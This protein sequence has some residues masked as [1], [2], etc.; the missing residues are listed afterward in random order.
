VTVTEDGQ[1][2]TRI[3]AATGGE[4]FGPSARLRSVT[5]M[6]AT[7]AALAALALVGRLVVAA[8]T[9]TLY[10]DDNSTC[11]T[12]CGTPAAPFRTITDA[13][14]DADARIVAGSAS[15]ATIQVAAGTYAAHIYILPNIHVICESPATTTIDA[16]GDVRSAVILAAGLTGRVRTDFSIRNCRITGGIGEV[17]AASSRIAGGG[18]FVLGDAVVSNNVITGNIMSGAEPNWVGA[19]VYVGYGDPIIIGNLITGNVANPPPLGGGSNDSL[20]IGG[21]IHVE[22]SGAG[23]VVTHARIEANTVADNVAQGEVGKG[24]GIRVDGAAGTLVTRNIIYGNRSAFGGGGMM[25][26]GNVTVADNLLYGNSSTQY[27]GGI[28]LYQATARVINNTIFGNSLTLATAPSGYAYA[29]YGGAVCVDALIS[30]SGNP[31]VLVSNNLIAG[32]SVTP[33]G[34]TAGLHSHIT[35]PIITYTDFWSNMKV[36]ATLDNIGG[37]F[38]EA[39]VIGVNNNAAVDPLFAHPPLFADVSVAAGTTTTVAVLMASRYL[40]NQVL[41]LNN[42]GVARTI[43]NVNTSTNVLTFT[44]ALPAASQAFKLLA[45]WGTSTDATEDF[46]LQPTSPVVD[47]GTN[48]PAPGV[49]VSSLDLEGQP[50]IQDGNNDNVPTV[51]LGAYEFQVPDCDGDGVTNLLDCAPCLATVQS[52]PGPVGPSLRVGAGTPTLLTWAKIPQAYVFNVYRGTFTIGTPFSYNHVC[53]ETNSPDLVAQDASN[54]P[55]G[56]AYYYLVSGANVCQEGCL[57]LVSPPGACEIPNASPCSANPTADT[58]GDTVRDM[59]DNCPL[60][61]NATQ[62]DGD[63][64]S[65]GDA[66]DNC[67]T[68]A[69]PDQVDSDSDGNGD[70]CQDSDHDGFPSDVDCNDLSPSVHPGAIETCNA[71][72]DDCD[73]LVDES[74]GFTTCGT[75]ACARQVNNCVGGQPQTC[76]PGTPTAEVCNGIDDDCDGSVDDLGSTTCGVGACQRSVEACVGGVPQTCTPG[77]PTTEVCNGIDDDCDGTVDEGFAGSD[78]DGDGILDCQDPDDDNDLVPD[79]SD[80]APLINSVSAVPGEVGATVRPLSSIPPESFTFT[81]IAQA[82]VHQVY[83][84]SATTGPTYLTNIACRTAEIT[85][86]GFNEPENPPR[87]VIFYYLIAGTNR[88]GE[89]T[90]GLTS[91]GQPRP[92]SVACTPQGL[93]S[94]GDPVLDIDDNCPRLANPTQADRDHDGR[95]DACDNCPDV[96]NP[97]QEDSDGN[98]TGDAC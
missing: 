43:T 74:L 65:V 1:P 89:G 49:P 6:F 23:V 76:T 2:N 14:T 57:G 7:V 22:G 5:R 41:E 3:P 79:A 34:N 77:T 63:R 82:N 32:N 16:T 13:I 59:D 62:V 68:R 81:P 78:T 46:R 52:A 21:G 20:G 50:R 58:D 98:G 73:S 72:D 12:G 70:A 55:R 53:L 69:N 45:N 25:V 48:L 27:G 9:V 40:V 97:G 31:Q 66:C 92:I 86:Y 64:D 85:T 94:D 19:G 15:G 54:P 93:N 33:A 39:Q 61:A 17:R 26:Y 29:N 4:S 24:G 84:G 95:G 35:S 67:P 8:G 18:V 96:A 80:C 56:T 38:V 10:V 83:R 30:Q 71:Q 91:A 87:G 42:D 88:C 75:G 37:D 11:T 60:I 90:I 28:N 44:P 36:P 47:A 51:D